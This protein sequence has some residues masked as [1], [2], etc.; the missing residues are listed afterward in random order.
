M[1]G[2]GDRFRLLHDT[3]HHYLAGEQELFPT[4]RPRPHLRRRGPQPAN[5]IRDEHRVLVGPADIM[6]NIGQIRALR[7]GGYTGPFS[8]EPFS[9]AVHALPDP[10]G[11][12]HQSFSFRRGRAGD[13]A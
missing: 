6:D 9:P 4:D 5:A 1:I 12:L 3:F 7:G 8:L 11:A 13:P 2:A 10:A